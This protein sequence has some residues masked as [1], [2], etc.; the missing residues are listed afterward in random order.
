VPLAKGERIILAVSKLNL[1]AAFALG[2]QSP[3]S[4]QQIFTN[5]VSEVAA[6]DAAIEALESSLAAAEVSPVADRRAPRKNVIVYYGV[7]GIG[8]SMLSHQLANR[9]VAET[10]DKRRGPRAAIRFDF[11][12]SASFDLES[13][14][15]RLRAGVAHL[16][17]SWPAFD[18]ALSVYWAR[19]HPGEPL[20]QFINR[21]SRLRRAAREIGMSEQIY[22]TVADITGVLPAAANVAYRL[23]GIIYGR[24]KDAVAAHR[25]L[26]ECE[27]LPQLIEADADLETLSYF[28]YLLAWDL[29]R[30]SPPHLKATV[31]L[32]TY[33]A[34]TSR[35]TRDAE[36]YLQRSVFL[37]PNALFVVTGRNRLDWAELD[38]TDELDFVGV[39]RWPYLRSGQPNDP[40]QH[41]VGYLSVEDAHSYL[42]NA[43]TTDDQPAIPPDIRERVVAASAGLP[44]Y[45]DLAVTM[46]LDMLARG[47]VPSAMDFGQPLPAVAAQML[48]DLGKDERDLLRASALLDGFD[49]D[50]LRA[51]CPHIPDAALRRFRDRPF[52]DADPDRVWRYSLHDVLRDAIR[53]ADKD[54]PDSWSPRE[55]AQV[56][57]RIAEHLKLIAGKAAQTGY[58]STE[59]AAVQQAIGL[60]S[61][62]GQFF[63]W[64]VDAAQQ[65]L[66]SG[67]WSAFDGEH[68]ASGDS[69]VSALLLGLEGARE[70]RS[71]R[72][73]TAMAMA[74]TALRHPD[75]PSK[76]R[77]FLTLHRAHALRVAGRYAEAAADYQSLWQVASDF[78]AEAGYWVADY[79]FLGGRFDDALHALGQL[80]DESPQL[81]GEMLRLRGHVFRVNAM[82]ADA[83]SQ[84]R[85]ALDLA[86][87]T[88]NA[89]AEGK[90]LTDLVQTLEWC[91]P[92]DAHALLPSAIAA[93]EGVRNSI[94]LV[95]LRAAAAVTLT[96]QGDLDNAD[97]E[98]DHGLS[99][100]DQ[101]G[102][103]GGKIWCWVARAFNRL[104]R[105][106][107]DGYL[108]AVEQVVTI[109]GELGGNRFWGEIAR[110]WATPPEDALPPSNTRWLGGEGAA[111]QRWHAAGAGADS[112]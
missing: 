109:A 18:L 23:A 11:A 48:R 105:G 2:L 75:L 104:R 94:E 91:R 69:A 34:V 19:A 39:E 63:D 36:R 67:H 68:D 12:E 97:A 77:W 25:T 62:T 60:C 47:K 13:Y 111:R 4:A 37:M 57:A 14:I 72:L 44:L 107:Q 3:V 82:F 1:R 76:L 66:T 112:S 83:E 32:D 96:N 33:E 71:G 80:P 79:S 95:K 9:Y 46:Y 38:R 52:L 22:A 56:A 30:L 5:R 81:R 89:A 55:R 24:V 100:A 16:A 41:L 53:E 31:F 51:A 99:L 35:A 87:E 70:R 73:D 21:D 49:L 92:A 40:R 65:L 29:Q 88:A 15:L 78:S 45:L 102:Y 50:V 108:V 85:Q 103:P 93:N 10:N 6:F 106:D 20:E 61:L 110:W 58:R 26:R 27:L 101:C 28:P 54:L 86:R 42:T 98:I 74:D 43:V 84:Y 90:A 59:V 7:G 64:L 8:K 17:K